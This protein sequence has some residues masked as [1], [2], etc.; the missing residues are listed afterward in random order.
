MLNPCSVLQDRQSSQ[1]T[2]TSTGCA[3]SMLSYLLLMVWYLGAFRKTT[4]LEEPGHRFGSS[5]LLYLH[6]SSANISHLELP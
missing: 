6:P 2:T 4:P 1:S 5:F 3:T